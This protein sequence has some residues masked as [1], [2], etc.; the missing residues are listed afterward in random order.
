MSDLNKETVDQL[1]EVNK[2]MLEVL[3]NISE[4]LGDLEKRLDQANAQRDEQQ[5]LLEKVAVSLEF[6][7]MH[8]RH[9]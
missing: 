1:L 4:Q 6:T 7:E 3:I 5:A 2:Y 9:M 8:T